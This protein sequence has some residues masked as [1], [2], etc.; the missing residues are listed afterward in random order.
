[1]THGMNTL[2]T[3][4]LAALLAVATLACGGSN[5]QQGPIPPQAIRGDVVLT[6]NA[7]SATAFNGYVVTLGFDSTFMVAKMPLATNAGE[8]GIGAG[9]VCTTVLGA[10]DYTLTCGNPTALMGPGEIASFTLE[11]DDFVPVAGDFTLDCEF[12]D[13]NGVAI[14]VGCDFDMDV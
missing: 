13:E 4:L 11:Y 7:T 5:G 9:M 8:S 12:V 2:K 10:D 14:V 1:M 6:V 3:G